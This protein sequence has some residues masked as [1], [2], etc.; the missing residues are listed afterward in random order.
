MSKEQEKIQE[1]RK[2]VAKDNKDELSATKNEIIALGKKAVSLG[3]HSK[4]AKKKPQLMGNHREK[5]KKVVKQIFNKSLKLSSFPVNNFEANQAADIYKQ[6]V[7]K[8]VKEVFSTELSGIKLQYGQFANPTSAIIR[9]RRYGKGTD[10]IIENCVKKARITKDNLEKSLPILKNSLESAFE[11]ELILQQKVSS[12]LENKEIKLNPE[13][14]E[15]ISSNFSKAMMKVDAK[16]IRENAANIESDLESSFKK[17]L[18]EGK[19]NGSEMKSQSEAIAEKYNLDM[20]EKFINDFKQEH[21]SYFDKTLDVMKG[22][23]EEKNI[24]IDFKQYEG[25]QKQWHEISNEV[26]EE[27]E[28]IGSL[29]L[30][31][32]HVEEISVKMS[33]MLRNVN[34][35][36][37]NSFLDK[38]D[39]KDHKYYLQRWE[40]LI[41]KT[42]DA[43]I[44]ASQEASKAAFTKDLEQKEKTSFEKDLELEK[45]IASDMKGKE[46]TAKIHKVIADMVEENPSLKPIDDKLKRGFD[47]KQQKYDFGLSEDK[48]MKLYESAQ[49][50]SK[51]LSEDNTKEIES[52]RDNINT[53]LPSTRKVKHSIGNSRIKKEQS[54]YQ[55]TFD[56]VANDPDSYL[57]KLEEEKKEL[58]NRE[59]ELNKREEILNNR[60]REQKEIE[61][62]PLETTRAVN[63]PSPEKVEF[64]S[65]TISPEKKRETEIKQQNSSLVE[66]NNEK[67]T[68][69]KNQNVKQEPDIAKETIAPQGQSKQ[70]QSNDRK[71]PMTQEQVEQQ[72]EKLTD[73]V[74]N[75]VILEQQRYMQE[76]MA[77]TKEGEEKEDFLK[78]D[79]A[80]FRLFLASQDGKDLL[81]KVTKD[82][83][84]EKGL[85][86]REVKG[87]KAMINQLGDDAGDMKWS[88]GKDGT[89]ISEIQNANGEVICKLSEKNVRQSNQSV[90][91]SDGSTQSINAHREVDFPKEFESGKGPAFFYMAVQDANGK[92]IAEKDAVYFTASYDKSGKLQEVSS[93]M[94]VKFLGK[95]DDAIG[96]IEREGKAYTIPVT[97]GKYR[98]M[99][100]EVAKNNGL[101]VDASVSVEPPSIDLQKGINLEKAAA[102]TQE[103]QQAKD[104]INLEKDEKIKSQQAQSE[105]MMENTKQPKQKK[106]IS[107]TKEEELENGVKN[108]KSHEQVVSRENNFSQKEPLKKKEKQEGVKEK[109]DGPKQKPFEKPPLKRQGTLK[110][111]EIKAIVASMRKNLEEKQRNPS[112]K[113]NTDG[114]QKLIA[115]HRKN[116]NEKSNSHGKG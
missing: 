115:Q 110:S 23:A 65:Q 67:E 47:E 44:K 31:D 45:N 53:A 20:Q 24:K 92:N 37:I 34:T 18:K 94:P 41:P 109:Q 91:L 102:P 52:M 81:D 50:I 73:I 40:E 96:Y 5:Y 6:E 68:L 89:R 11:G 25:L 80:S 106:F 16:Y 4:N 76:E 97:Q 28:K 100:Q 116:Q 104:S 114:A 98:E 56:S 39:G 71:A 8:K 54:N 105:L 57:K 70:A 66:Q 64:E 9:A 107:K 38:E 46:R 13:Q 51:G 27:L 35:E 63:E 48:Y 30:D 84:V 111:E 7:G 36:F 22:K 87:Y 83:A 101:G 62:Q 108:D 112:Q 61:K 103:I 33:S 79:L 26:L 82:P 59:K 2:S 1:Q 3:G 17:V 72:V 21:Y 74:R 90:T 78:Q 58:D 93:P 29:K 32:K 88:E 49:R 86:E 69:L 19:V 42:G 85:H 77:K 10:H 12:M 75:D 99:M 95:G 55:N 113:R 60:E 15:E 14:Y 43:L